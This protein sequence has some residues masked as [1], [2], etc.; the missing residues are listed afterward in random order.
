MPFMPRGVE[1]RGPAR[2]R[3][4]AAVDRERDLI[5]H[6]VAPIRK[7]TPAGQTCP[8]TCASTSSGKC[9]MTEAIG[10]VDDLAE[11]ADRR[12]LHRVAQL[13]EQREVVRAAP[14]LASTR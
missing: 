2:D 9:F 1:D 6:A 3:D 4:V 13:L 11:A 10:D 12:H 7:Q 8:S 5:A 14:P